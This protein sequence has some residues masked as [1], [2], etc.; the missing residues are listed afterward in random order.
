MIAKMSLSSVVKETGGTLSAD[1]VFTRVS[2]DT[3]DIQSG[4]LFV[5]L[6]GDSF[7]G[8]HYLP[9]A[10]EKGASAVVVSIVAKTSVPQ[11]QVSDTRLAYGIIARQNRRRFNGTV[12]AITGSSGK[13][14]TKEM[15]AAIL[16]EC[17]AV[18]ATKKNLNNEVGVPLTLLEI[19]GSHQYAVIELGA[20]AVGDI[21]Y[22]A[23]FAEP[24]IAVVTNAMPVHI[25]GFGSI[26]GVAKTKGELFESL[27]GNGIAVV[28][29]DDDFY[30]Q[31]QRQAGD[32]K[33]MTFSRD[34]SAADIFARDIVL[35]KTGATHFSLCYQDDTCRIELCLLGMHNVTNA[36]AAAAAGLSA[37]ADLRQV[38]KGL[39]KV[40]PVSGRLKSIALDR[41]TVIDD[42]YNASPDSVRAAIDVLEGFSGKRCLVLG[43]MAELGPE[44][45]KLH[46]EVAVYAREK[47]IDQFV[48]V[49]EFAKVMA[50]SFG[51]SAVGYPS[52]DK[53]LENLDAL[54]MS[55][56]VLV[57]GSRS[58]HMERVVQALVGSL[59]QSDL[60]NQIRPGDA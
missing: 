21:E 1:A 29:K 37:G 23:Q 17:G 44:A 9:E 48:A 34:N 7:D 36:I 30:E 49:G 41:L 58:A 45:E 19:D 39:E 28:N 24:D 31:W 27:S 46:E 3:R 51:G 22:L 10:V 52:M 15:I 5:A 18:V 13:T 26:Q 4:D 12:V 33:V 32:A 42:T 50:A 54:L 11:L 8:H 14:T 60:P 40:R 55:E 16:S 53:L 57:K 38:K 59:K 56:M 2:T 47:K 35:D 25:E 43:A 6:K 20:S